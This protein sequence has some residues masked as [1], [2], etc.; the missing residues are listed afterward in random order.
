MGKN[1]DIELVHL[2]TTGQGV[3]RKRV[4]PGTTGRGVP[5]D[6][7]CGLLEWMRALSERLLRVRVCSGDWGRVLSPSAMAA[8]GSGPRGIFFDP[9]YSTDAERHM[10]CYSRDSGT[11]AHDVRAWCLAAPAEYRIALCGYEGEGHE[12]LEHV[13]WT[14]MAWTAGGG[15]S[16]D[17]GHGSG[18]NNE[19]ERIWFS[20]ACVAV[21]R[22]RQLA[23]LD[24]VT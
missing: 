3:S 4:H 9:P 17:K 13:G 21:E 10:G 23:L 24:E 6:G 11:V 5:G 15:L 19:R 18:G 22:P 12:A 14:C 16:N 8:G 7:T 1:S 2:G 20:P